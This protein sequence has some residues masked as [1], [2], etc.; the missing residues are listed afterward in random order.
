[1]S[2]NKI[3]ICTTSRAQISQIDPDENASRVVWLFCAL[4]HASDSPRALTLNGPAPITFKARAPA[5][6]EGMAGVSHEGS[7]E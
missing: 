3:D 4:E 2:T 6:I 7:M 1:M 5:I